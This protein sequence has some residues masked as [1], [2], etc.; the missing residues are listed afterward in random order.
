MEGIMKIV[1][2]EI[3]RYYQSEPNL[4]C[5]FTKFTKY[6]EE[7]GEGSVYKP[8]GTPWIALHV[9]SNNATNFVSFEVELIQKEI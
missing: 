7:Q 1:Q 8:I 6:F 3:Q 2:F 4:L 5:L 9:Y